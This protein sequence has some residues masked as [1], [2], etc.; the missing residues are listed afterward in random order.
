MQRI[1]PSIPLLFL[2]IVTSA[3]G[4]V[5][6]QQEFSTTVADK[7]QWDLKKLAN[8]PEFEW[9]DDQSSIRSLVYTGEPF[10]GQPTKVF[11][12]YASPATLSGA[13][14]AEG[15][16][17]G[18]V[19]LHG[20]GGTAF[21]EWVQLWAKRGYAAIAMDLGGDRPEAPKYQAGTDRIKAGRVKRVRLPMGGPADEAKQ[22]FDNVGGNREDDWQFHAV[23]NAIRAHSLIRSFAEVRADQ[24]AVTGISWGGYLTC[25]TASIDHRFKAAVPVYGCGF[26]YDGESVQRPWID[27]LGPEKRQLWIDLYDPSRWLADCRTPIMFVNGV[28]DKHYPLRSYIR[29]YR[30]VPGSKQIQLDPQMRH[31]HRPGWAPKEIGMFVDQHLLGK[32]PLPK[33]EALQRNGENVTATVQTKTRIKTATL[34]FTSDRGMQSKR[35]W[36]SAIA[37]LE[38]GKLSAALP[39]AAV[40]Y[41]FSVRDQR[42]ALVTSEVQFC[43]QVLDGDSIQTQQREDEF[44]PDQSLTVKVRPEGALVLLDPQT[45]RFVS[46]KGDKPDWPI[47]NGELVSTRGERRSNHV[48]STVYFQDAD[49]HVEFKTN[50]DGNGNSGI[51]IHGLYEIQ[52]F[53]SDA[54][55]QQTQQDL[56]ALYGF[57]KPLVAAGKAPGEW[58]VFDIRYIAPRSNADGEITK[59]GEV[60]VWLN[61]KKVQD[62]TKF[63]K[64]RSKYNPYVYRSTDYLKKILQQQKKTSKGPMFL[65][66][67]DNP[68]RFR[69]IWIKPLD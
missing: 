62:R 1:S 50:Q 53:N 64:A 51:Y 52:I 34:H 55:K 12:F 36:Q 6:G 58:Q 37:K 59:Q 60:T 39:K 67:H 4:F 66:D 21:A 25:L 42:D 15:K 8:A 3:I 14:A 43:Q 9:I 20:G 17:P 56:G 65:Q 33:I 23:S 10:Q 35:R 41:F 27:A 18:I 11:A 24:T 61:G 31:G 49:I 45:L 26:L 30:L 63:G 54:S 44:E 32:T 19:L 2:A 57:A 29:S 69:N 16:Y 13:K 5:E 68:V 47:E 28:N 7:H 46:K 48:L 38:N 22:K 40:S